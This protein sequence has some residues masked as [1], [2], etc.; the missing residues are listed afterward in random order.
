M[1]VEHV[2][3]FDGLREYQYLVRWVF[4]PLVQK[5][6]EYLSVVSSDLR[7]EEEKKLLRKTHCRTIHFPQN[8]DT[9]IAGP[10]LGGVSPENAISASS[11]LRAICRSRN[12]CRN[13]GVGVGDG[14]AIDKPLVPILNKRAESAAHL[15]RAVRWSY[16]K[17]E[18]LR[19]LE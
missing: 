19:G 15:F 7:P 10:Y 2:Q 4:L 11:L 16:V 8:L 17:T 14:V 1:E 6:L 9:S 12:G 3:Q 18:A 13:R 5:R